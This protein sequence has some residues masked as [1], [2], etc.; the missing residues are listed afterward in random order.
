MPRTVY[1]E[2]SYT[3]SDADAPPPPPPQGSDYYPPTCGDITFNAMRSTLCCILC[4]FAILDPVY[5]SV[6][7][8]EDVPWNRYPVSG[9]PRC[10]PDGSPRVSQ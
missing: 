2:D 10:N 9:G 7:V 1:E 5:S 4:V 8:V 3:Y 6:P